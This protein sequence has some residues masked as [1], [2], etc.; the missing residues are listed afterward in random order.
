MTDETEKDKKISSAGGLCVP[1]GLFIGMGIG[2]ALGYLVPGLL[3]GL[4]AGLLLM[5]LVQLKAG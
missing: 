2:W 1:A 3:I 5:A 4:G